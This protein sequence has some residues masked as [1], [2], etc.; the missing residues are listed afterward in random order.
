MPDEGSM[1]DNMAKGRGI[2]DKKVFKVVGADQ[3]DR[4]TGGS[5][6]DDPRGRGRPRVDK[7]WNQ[8]GKSPEAESGQGE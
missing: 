6:Q 2:V 3:N 1:Q 8:V 7:T 5:D 4:D